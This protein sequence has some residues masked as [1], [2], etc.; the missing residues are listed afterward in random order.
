MDVGR[1][2][3]CEENLISILIFTEG[4]DSGKQ[5]LLENNNWHSPQLTDNQ[6]T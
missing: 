5:R 3:F 2:C 1:L 6:I 4:F